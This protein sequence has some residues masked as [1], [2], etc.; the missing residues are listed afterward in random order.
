MVV[1]GFCAGLTGCAATPAARED[2]ANRKMLEMIMPIRLTIVEPFTRVAG[3]TDSSR[4]QN[5]AKPGFVGPDS[6]ELMLQAANIL[7]SPCVMLV[8]NIRVELYEFVQASADR[9]GRRLEFWN[10]DLTGPE[11]QRRHWNRVTQMYEF[12]LGIDPDRVP[13]AERYVMLVTYNSP[14]GSNVSDEAVLELRAGRR[15]GQ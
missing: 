14:L 3:L 11:D 8:G 7:D 9:K 1:A 5:T 13:P 6:I 4:G 10:V 12:R 2:A 15:S